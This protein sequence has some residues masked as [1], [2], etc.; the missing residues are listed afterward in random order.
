MAQVAGEEGHLVGAAQHDA[1]GARDLVH[2]GGDLVPVHA[3]GGLL[4]VGV[5]GRQSRLELGLVD[6]EQRLG[7]EFGGAVAALAAAAV[8]VA[9]GGLE[10]R[11]AVEAERLRKAHDG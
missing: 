11:E 6:R 7:C 10:L 1:V 2:S 4:H 5:V 3:P 8:L 9:R